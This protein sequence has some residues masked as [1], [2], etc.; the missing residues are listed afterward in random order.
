MLLFVAFIQLAV[1][2]ES[3]AGMW[4]ALQMLAFVGNYFDVAANWTFTISVAWS[5]CVDFQAAIVLAR[6]Y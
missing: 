1:L 3:H 5:V 2:G 6:G 4:P